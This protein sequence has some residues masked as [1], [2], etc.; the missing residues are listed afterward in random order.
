MKRRGAEEEDGSRMSAELESV[1]DIQSRG[2]EGERE[3]ER[4]AQ[5]G[6]KKK[7][8]RLAAAQQHYHE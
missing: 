5:R 7:K 1:E 4:G 8:T 2:A 3:R 6:E